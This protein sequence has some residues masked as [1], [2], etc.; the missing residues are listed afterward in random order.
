MKYELTPEDENCLKCYR[1]Y[2]EGKPGFE[3]DCPNIKFDV[4]LYRINNNI[5]NYYI[6]P[7]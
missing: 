7:N 1:A 3:P 2:E 4:I 5:G 6:F